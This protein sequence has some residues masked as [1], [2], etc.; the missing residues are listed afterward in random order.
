MS[1]KITVESVPATLRAIRS[2]LDLTQTELANRLGKLMGAKASGF[3]K[4]ESAA[5]GQYLQPRRCVQ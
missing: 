4:V 5:R 3:V 2:K 1:E